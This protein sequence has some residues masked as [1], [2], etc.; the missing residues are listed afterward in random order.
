MAVA[1]R[2]DEIDRRPAAQGL[3]PAGPRGEERSLQTDDPQ[4]PAAERMRPPVDPHAIDL[5]LALGFTSASLVV[6]LAGDTP[7]GFR[8]PDALGIGLVLLATLPLA[9]MRFQA[10]AAY[11]AMLA[12]DL[13][14]PALDYEAGLP[15]TA[16]LVVGLFIIA[17]TAPY[18]QAIVAGVS[19]G[20]LSLVVIVVFPPE[21]SGIAQTVVYWLAFSGTWLLGLILKLS[22]ESAARATR[23]ATLFAQDRELRAA[24]AVAQERARLAR[25]LHDGVGHALNVVVLHAQGARRLL[26][27]KPAL[28]EEALVSIETAGRQALAD[29]ER[30]L[31]VLHAE[32]DDAF[33]ARPGLD[34]LPTLAERVG[35]AGLPVTLDVQWPATPLPSSV[36]LTAYRIVQ[37]ALTNSLKHAGNAEASVVVRRRDGGLELEILD[38]GRGAAAAA[39]TP[40]EGGRG[41][42]GMRER[43]AVFGGRL[44]TGPRAEGG[45]RVWAWLPL[46]DDQGGDEPPAA[47]GEPR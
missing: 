20:L 2:G 34:R 9:A 6:F 17:L 45:F 36:D 32:E 24:E 39:T 23:R 30:M 13:L 21:G 8:D 33:A 10:L 37:E 22:R 35:E 43:V 27:S 38:T 3:P 11:G 14:L 7:A 42:P 40:A 1:A 25:E 5:L 47:T 26:A 12:G 44:E 41:I 31:G 4:N 16:A 28:A 46:A 19:T 18:W 15:V 29:V